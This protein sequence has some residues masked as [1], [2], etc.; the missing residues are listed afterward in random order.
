MAQSRRDENFVTTII[1]VSSVD[2][3][4]PT[5][6][7]VNPTTKAV[8]AEI[9]S[10]DHGKTLL[11]VGGQVSGLGNNTLVSAGT[12]RLKVYAFSLSTVSITAV[13]C[14]FQS[15]ASGTELWRVTLQ[16]PAGVAGGANLAVSP[17]AWLFAT[18]SATALNLN[19]SAAVAVDWSVSYFDEA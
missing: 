16:T 10:M 6:I 15:G 7:A 4:T 3:E 8:L 1:G 18:A 11:S 13:T 19:L 9:T 2:S 12:K 17:P 14:I 5:L